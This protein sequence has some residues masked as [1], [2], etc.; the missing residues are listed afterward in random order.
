V[1]GLIAKMTNTT[2]LVETNEGSQIERQTS[3]I[4]N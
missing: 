3:D 1:G 2:L 4:E